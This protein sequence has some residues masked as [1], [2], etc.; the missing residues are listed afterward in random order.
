MYF[1]KVQ[2]GKNEWWRYLVTVFGVA[3][4]YFLVGLIPFLIVIFIKNS[5]GI[6]IDPQEFAKTY[7]PEFLNI[8]QNMGMILML[9]PSWVM[10]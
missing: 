1:V 9:A 5:Q 7:N 10:A 3:F 4:T 6:P 8:S 2:K